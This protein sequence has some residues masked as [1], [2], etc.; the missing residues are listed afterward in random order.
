ML[1]RPSSAGLQTR[2]AHNRMMC[3]PSPDARYSHPLWN[4]VQFWEE[5]LTFAVAQ[6][7]RGAP[8]RIGSSVHSQ[9]GSFWR[10]VL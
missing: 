6:E 1:A 9:L 5:V 10:R 3:E 2:L 7:V 4:R 8:A